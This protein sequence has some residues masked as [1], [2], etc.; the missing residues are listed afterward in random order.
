MAP[1]RNRKIFDKISHF[2]PSVVNKSKNLF[3]SQTQMVIILL[4][5]P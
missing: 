4:T 3:Q 5:S 1:K 2:G